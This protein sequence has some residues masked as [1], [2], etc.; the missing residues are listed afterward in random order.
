[1]KP[2]INKNDTMLGQYNTVY[3]HYLQCLG[4]H[5]AVFMQCGEFYESYCYEDEN[6]E[7]TCNAFEL[8]ECMNIMIK[9]HREGPLSKTNPWI[10]G[11]PRH[12]T[13]KFR[14]ILLNN[15]YSV[16]FCDEI[17]SETSPKQRIVG[18]I[19]TPGIAP[20]GKMYHA[21]NVMC[22]F[23]EHQNPSIALDEKMNRFD[24]LELV[25]GAAAI[26]VNTNESYVFEVASTYD[27]ILKGESNSIEEIYRF[28]RSNRCREL[29]IHLKRFSTN[30][31]EKLK[32]YFVETLGLEEFYI[33]D[34]GFDD[35]P[36]E[37]CNPK[38]I[39]K[40]F[41]KVF[42]NEVVATTPLE[43]MEMTYMMNAATALV[44]LI[45][46]IRVRNATLTFNLNK[47]KHWKSNDRLILTHNAQQQLGLI[48]YD[49]NKKK[50][51]QV[52]FG[53]ERTLFDILDNTSTPMG[54]RLL[55]MILLQPFSDPELLRKK[56]SDLKIIV[57][58]MPG[59]ADILHKTLREIVDLQKLHRKIELKTL[60]PKGLSKLISSYF[61]IKR[62]FILVK[63]DIGLDSVGEET[64]KE[65]ENYVN[66]LTS[67]F[68][69]EKLIQC[70]SSKGVTLN[71]FQKGISEEIDDLSLRAGGIDQYANKM[72]R[73]LAILLEENAS[74]DKIEKLV[75]VEIPAKGG[76]YFKVPHS[77][78]GALL[79]Y[80]QLISKAQNARMSYEEMKIPKYPTIEDMFKIHSEEISDAHFLEWGK[81]MMAKSKVVAENPKTYLT[82]DEIRLVDSCGKFSALKSSSK[83]YCKLV[84]DAELSSESVIS[85]FVEAMT[86][87]YFEY[88]HALYSM[89]TKTLE[90]VTAW[91]ANLDVLK[92]NAVAAFKGRYVC[93][94]I[95]DGS[96]SFI[97]A[98]EIRH[99]IIE[100]LQKDIPYIPN[101][102]RLGY[103]R[104][105]KSEIIS[106]SSNGIF[107]MSVN[108]GGKCLGA[109]VEILMGDGS[110]KIAK[111]IQKFD[112]LIGDD[113][114]PRIVIGTTKGRGQMYRISKHSKHEK[115]LIEGFEC[116]DKHML[117]F[118]ACSTTILPSVVEKG[119][120]RVVAKE[121]VSQ[122]NSLIVTGQNFVWDKKSDRKTDSIICNDEHEALFNA[123][124]YALMKKDKEHAQCTISAEEI[125]KRNKKSQ[126]AGTSVLID[127]T[128]QKIKRPVKCFP[129]EFNLRQLIN[130]TFCKLR[131]ILPRGTDP[132]TDVQ[133]AYY[134][135]VWLGD[136]SEGAVHQITQCEKLYPEVVIQLEKIAKA[137]GLNLIRYICPSKNDG[138][139]ELILMNEEMIKNNDDIKNKCYLYRLSNGNGETLNESQ[140]NL[141]CRV[142]QS[143]G[144]T[145]GTN[146]R[147]IKYIPHQLLSTSKK[148]RYALLAGLLDTDGHYRSDEHNEFEITQKRKE[149]SI[150]ICRLAR[151][152]G[153][154]SN[155]NFK[156]VNNYPENDYYRVSILG[157]HLYKIPCQIVAKRALK[158]IHERPRSELR[159]S[160]EI[161]DIGMDD[162]YGFQL[163][164]L[165][166][167]SLD[168]FLKALK[169]ID[170]KDPLINEMIAQGV[171]VC[172]SEKCEKINGRYPGRFLLGDFTVT[173]NTSYLKSVG[174]ST[175]MA[176]CGM[177]VP[178][179]KF[180]YGPFQ[181]IITRLSG[182]DNMYKRQGSF[183]VEME[184]LRTVM[185]QS[186]PRSLVLGDEICRGTEQKSAL[187]IVAASATKLCWKKTNFIFSTT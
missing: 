37:W 41:E 86:H 144:M 2:T 40:V 50:S 10:A 146:S 44:I 56:Y 51:K 149:L 129:I 65:F 30:C 115:K 113:G 140:S 59:S 4:N 122:N 61:A 88:L 17:P 178:A 116:N 184:E 155:I 133:F 98:E 43:Y 135:G 60:A 168:V 52:S 118:E 69:K 93:P 176:Q 162:Y 57:E 32:K 20:S 1:M 103:C 75:K 77:V 141:L 71:V 46:Y 172:S 101:D 34:I 39:N 153:F 112:V 127:K 159:Y 31:P 3:N 105:E 100:F 173:H 136:G 49:V 76:R 165:E 174:L 26:D 179:K 183:A 119:R 163:A 91:V 157:D 81:K 5:I 54:K 130:E 38:Y 83:V 64:E 11:F 152:L 28:L 102:V 151:S 89:N 107:L 27:S 70:K 169:E 21:N 9:K 35:I 84:E 123:R 36:N 6:G 72:A 42:K 164:M 16:I 58:K 80:R 53:A 96:D 158:R 143:L 117:V 185:N 74:E 139:A 180:L 109:N 47:V 138:E 186:G 24:K 95:T 85:S 18:D 104:N 128:W 154:K 8:A 125:Y 181:N 156:K 120:N 45:E 68:D 14:N 126:Q 97:R 166:N 160:A 167:V 187:A 92:S 19:I 7:Y 94:E 124:F 48:S 25:I 55:E 87:I 114:T 22:L 150:M 142:F 170:D 132:I 13:N 62:L 78:R 171:L 182:N 148:V 108:N 67:T 12:Q 106:P 137:C 23:I 73:D 66:I 161:T 110:I 99:P 79:H 175:I 15:N 177:F 90:K 134:A 121:F 29:S 82:L 111:N 131:I 33:H 145:E 147:G 63:E